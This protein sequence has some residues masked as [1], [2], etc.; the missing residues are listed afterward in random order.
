MR[1]VSHLS[2][3]I[4]DLGISNTQFADQAG[5]ARSTVQKL[6]GEDFKEI[7]VDTIERIAARLGTTDITSLFTLRDDTEEF[8]APFRATKSV[9]FLVGTHD[10]EDQ[11]QG[12]SRTTIDVWDFR[13]QTEFLQHVR[14]HVP[15]LRDEMR[16][17]SK[18]SF[19][20]AQRD[21]VL[22]LARKQNVVV[23]GSPKVN[24]AC[25]LVLRELFPGAPRGRKR[26]PRLR[27][28]ERPLEGSILGA[29]EGTEGVFVVEAATGRHLASA[30]FAG[31]EETSLDAGIVLSVFRP[32]QT[33]DK[34]TLVVVSGV[35][36]CGTYG[37]MRGLIDRPPREADLVP[38][39][40]CERAY[41]TWYVKPTDSPR[42]DRRVERV[43]P[44]E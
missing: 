1:V 39:I 24:P 27:I 20:D 32:W 41:Q 5:V 40:P 2:K 31:T 21:E 38:G 19:G 13:A 43:E 15:E 6:I 4:R 9:T 11:T 26:G 33:K 18:E 37:A 7:R 3:A 36:G 12:R 28:S 10:V 29:A 44:R 42:D 30:K 8:L 23:I 17:F 35:S 25:E 14:T 34:V 16:F 22:A